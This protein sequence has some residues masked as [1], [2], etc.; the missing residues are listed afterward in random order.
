MADVE[1]K[2]ETGGSL[3]FAGL[4][5]WVAGLLVLFYLPAGYRLG[6]QVGFAGILIVLAAI[7]AV[8]MGRGWSLR[9]KDNSE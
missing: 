3:M 1:Q 6:H 8:L 2:Q 7:G 9:R 5:I 4:A